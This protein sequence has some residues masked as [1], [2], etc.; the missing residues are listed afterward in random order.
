MK[1]SSNYL[2]KNVIPKKVRLDSITT[3]RKSRLND[4]TELILWIEKNNLN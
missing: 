4:S 2:E 1:L 3:M